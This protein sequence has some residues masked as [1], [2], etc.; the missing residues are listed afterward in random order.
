MIGYLLSSKALWQDILSY[1]FHACCVHV[2]ETH[3]MFLLLTWLKSDLKL[4]ISVTSQGE[5][6]VYTYEFNIQKSVY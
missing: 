5:K 3:D 1:Y 4:I 6:T 2:Y